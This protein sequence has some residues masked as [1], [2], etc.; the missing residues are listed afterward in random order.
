MKK[1]FLLTVL[2]VVVSVGLVWAKPIKIGKLYYLLDK[3]NHTATVTSPGT[4][5]HYTKLYRAI[6]PESVRYDSV[7]YSVTGIGDEA[8]NQCS[9]L[10]KVTIP[11]SVTHI[12][13]NAFLN[14]PKLRKVTIPNSVTYIGNAA[15]SNLKRPTYNAHV[16]AYLPY[17]YEGDYTV[18]EGIEMIAGGAFAGCRRLTGLTI[19]NSV[20]SVGKDAFFLCNNITEPVYNAHVFAYLPKYYSDEYTIP[21]GIETIVSSAFDDC[22]L[23][24]AVNIPNSVTSIGNKAF[25]FCVNLSKLEI[26][27]SVT[28][29]GESAF[30]SCASLTSI[31]IPGSVTH[32]GESAFSGCFNLTSVTI[33]DGVTDI[34]RNAFLSCASLSS[35]TIPNS[36]TSIGLYAFLY[37]YSLTEPVYNAHVFAHLPND[38]EGAYTI[39]EGIESI[40]G[41]AFRSC[42][43]LTA[44][45]IPASVTL[46]GGHVF[47]ECPNLTS[48]TCHAIT[49]P[50]SEGY[51]FDSK[52]NP[53]MLYVP[54]ESVFHYQYSYKWREFR[55]TDIQPI[56]AQ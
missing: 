50:V 47:T 46:I 54:T 15:F 42:E 18:P 23:L 22:Y 51:M 48:V 4:R 43:Q 11:K 1:H 12:G 17:S 32:I 27:N 2:M 16:F 45:T 44:L 37:C 5:K 49:P 55:D 53:V 10:K 24:T 39:P 30:T 7:T 14:C 38:Y 35:I 20:T 56:P 36:V 34:G 29:I 6:I 13:N 26:P 19:P 33:A 41:G 52:S 40:A 31:T 28:H 21:E 8:F 25:K 3:E 9:D